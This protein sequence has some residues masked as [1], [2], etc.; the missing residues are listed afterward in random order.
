MA[1]E[2]LRDALE[3]THDVL[4][5]SKVNVATQFGQLPKIKG[6]PKEIQLEVHFKAKAHFPWPDKT[7]EFNLAPRVVSDATRVDW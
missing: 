5:T 4:A 2:A 3:I 6:N 7:Y 1:P